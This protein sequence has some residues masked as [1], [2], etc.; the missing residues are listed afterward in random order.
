VRFLR[1]AG[2]KFFER[3]KEA[4]ARGETV[5]CDILST[6]IKLTGM[7]ITY[8]DSTEKD[9]GSCT[10]NHTS[11]RMYRLRITSGLKSK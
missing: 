1:D 4:I 7:F 11:L 2:K 10:F 5:P 8:I 6:L 3:R 9:I